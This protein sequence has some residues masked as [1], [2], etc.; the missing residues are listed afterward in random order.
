MAIAE[1]RSHFINYE[2]Y[3]EGNRLQ[4]TADLSLPEINYKTSTMGGAGVAGEIDM[5]TIGHTE[6]IEAGITWR[7]LNVNVIKF[8]E[9]KTHSLTFRGANENYD[10]ATGNLIVEPVKIELRGLPTKGSLGK[11][12]QASESESEN[13][14]SIL[15]LKISIK[16]EDVYEY[17]K[18]N[19]INKIRGVDYL[20]DVRSALGY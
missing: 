18:L 4:G 2:V 14:F 9:P 20:A 19:G 16:N 3:D 5:P 12:E 1:N 15:Y 6:N 7:T 10:S 17:D 11:F 13:T 8:L